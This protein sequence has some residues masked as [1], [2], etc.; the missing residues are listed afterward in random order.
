MAGRPG[1]VV[2]AAVAVLAACT[3]GGAG[4]YCA[5][6]CL[7]W[8]WCDEETGLCAE[9][10]ETT[11]AKADFA[12]SFGARMVE[13]KFHV[14]AYD[15][16]LRRF[17]YGIEDDDGGLRWETMALATGQDAGFQPHLALVPAASGTLIAIAEVEPGAAFKAERLNGVWT[18]EEMFR[19]DRPLTDLQGFWSSQ[20]GLQVCA[21]D[22]DG[23]LLY[24]ESSGDLPMTVAPVEPTGSDAV[25]TAPCRTQVYGGR[26]III[27]AARP[28]GVLSITLGDDG[29]WE[30]S[31]IAAD[32]KAAALAFAPAENGAVVA[33]LDAVSGELQYATS[34]EGKLTVF[35]AD[36]EALALPAAPFPPPRLSLAVGPGGGAVHLAYHDAA[37]GLLRVR[38]LAQGGTWGEVGEAALADT[39]L[40]V[41]QVDAAGHAAVAGVR[42]PGGLSAPGT[43]EIFRF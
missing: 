36:P 14:A 22:A 19:L 4:K 41:V 38:Y 13:G 5:D 20:S 8:Q 2:V 27:S 10:G 32:V 9:T 37:E 3:E 16:V 11:V 34:Q 23:V 28:A 42:Y 6:G 1:A 43:V 7:A 12:P 35:T 30:A 24:G 26:R 29:G 31:V 39:F 33:F 21:G 40:P 18:L 17:L 15:R 25:A